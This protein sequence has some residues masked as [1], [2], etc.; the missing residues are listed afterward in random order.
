[1]AIQS[2]REML[3]QELIEQELSVTTWTELIPNIPVEAS[4]REAMEF[5]RKELLREYSQI[6]LEDLETLYRIFIQQEDV[7]E[8]DTAIGNLSMLLA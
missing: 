5:A 7:E 4:H 8:E 6:H 2:R 3:I 1:M